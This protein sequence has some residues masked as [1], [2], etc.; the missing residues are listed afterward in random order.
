[1]AAGKTVVV[2]DPGHGGPDVGATGPSGTK[3]KDVNLAVALGVKDRLITVGIT[4][5]LTRYDDRAVPLE[6]RPVV[7]NDAGAAAF[8]SIHCNAFDD[9]SAK[10]TETYYRF[11][12]PY[13]AA[14]AV[15]VHRTVLVLLERQ[16]RGLKTKLLKDGIRDYFAVLRGAKVPAILVELAFLTNPEEEKILTGWGRELAAAAVA[17]GIRKFLS[18]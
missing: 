1:M 8:V 18:L 9:P 3:E 12:E 7:A 11:N 2:I 15:C 16:D 13:S 17:W 10:G 6:A 14:L 4:P 5:V